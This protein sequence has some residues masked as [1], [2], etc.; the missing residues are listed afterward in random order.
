M[1]DY[2]PLLDG[3]QINLSQRIDSNSQ[4]DENKTITLHETFAEESLPWWLSYETDNGPVDPTFDGL[5]TSGGKSTVSLNT[6]SGLSGAVTALKGPTVNYGNWS[7]VRFYVYG[8]ETTIG[9]GS[10]A[11]HHF[12]LGDD[13][14]AN[15]DVLEG[16]DFALTQ[17]EAAIS[18]RNSGSI[19]SSF[20]S[21]LIDNTSKQDVGFRIVNNNKGDGRD[22]KCVANAQP[23]DQLPAEGGFPSQTDMSFYV[24]TRANT[25]DEVEMKIDGVV[26]QLV[27]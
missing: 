2:F 4:I 26:I 12:H 9:T 17:D 20:N 25:G 22:L 14:D 3:N 18:I 11:I 8:I 27:P 6:G 19:I 1:S 15:N 7:E 5:A 21:S 10:Q 13:K 23:F 24:S 16:F